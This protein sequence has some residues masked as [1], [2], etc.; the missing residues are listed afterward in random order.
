MH[1]VV[2]MTHLYIQPVYHRC[3]LGNGHIFGLPHFLGTLFQQTY[4]IIYRNMLL[5]SNGYIYIYFK[6]Q[7]HNRP[8]KNKT[9]WAKKPGLS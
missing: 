1:L 7:I 3:S 5:M 8:M 2:D 6:F 9:I 4:M